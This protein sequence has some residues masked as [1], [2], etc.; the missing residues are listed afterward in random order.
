MTEICRKFGRGTRG[1]A[2]VARM[3]SSGPWYGPKIIANCIAGYHVAKSGDARWP[4]T[5][6]QIEVHHPN[7]LKNGKAPSRKSAK[8]WACD[9]PDYLRWA[10]EEGLFTRT[11]MV[12]GT[13]SYVD[14]AGSQ[15]R[16]EPCRRV[17][18]KP[19]SRLVSLAGKPETA[20][21]ETR[22]V[23]RTR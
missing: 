9:K 7:E 2:P 21:Y 10:T 20:C 17:T 16:R 4:D 1:S 8:K 22:R 11:D 12:P 5:A 15:I 23:K 19:A 18:R 14:G 3:G 6:A 13:R